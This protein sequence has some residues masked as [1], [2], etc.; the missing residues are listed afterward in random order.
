MSVQSAINDKYTLEAGSALMSGPQALVTLM[1]AQY[2]ADHAAGLNTGGYVTGYR[3]S[4]L[5][6]VDQDSLRTR[7]ERRTRCDR[8]SRDPAIGLF[9]PGERR[10]RICTVVREGAGRRPRGGCPEAWKHGRIIPGRWSATGLR[11]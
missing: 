2:R 3:G 1:L 9:R 11:G 8:H 4:P 7:D 5:G 6:G 10:R